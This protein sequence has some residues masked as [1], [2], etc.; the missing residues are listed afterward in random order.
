S[1]RSNTGCVGGLEIRDT[2][3]WKSALRGSTLRRRF[4]PCA[5]PAPILGPGAQPRGHGV[6]SNISR[7]SAAFIII[8]HPMIERFGL[9]EP[10]FRQAENPFG[11]QRS[12]LLPA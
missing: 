7:D 11:A 3:D 9:P 6:V 8:P 1:T 2:A 5:A 10:S 4:T 12:E